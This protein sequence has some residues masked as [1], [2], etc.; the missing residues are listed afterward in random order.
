MSNGELPDG[1]ERAVAAEGNAE[2]RASE[3]RRT[4]TVGTILKGSIRARRRAGRRYDDAYHIDWHEPDL[5]FLSVTTVLLSVI[6]AFLTVTLLRHGAHEANP[7]L[8]YVLTHHPEIFAVVK[9][10][11]T[12]GGVLVL[13]ATARARLFRVIRVKTV[14]QWCLLG[15]VVLIGYELWLLRDAVFV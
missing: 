12:G 11:M 13:V 7:F 6:D 8:S 9:M 5:L 4:L 10:A 15:Y 14:L 3:E 2:R 1:P